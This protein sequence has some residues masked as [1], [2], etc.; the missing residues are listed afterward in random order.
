MY[1]LQVITIQRRI[2]G[3]EI[4]E[5]NLQAHTQRREIRTATCNLLSS[6]DDLAAPLSSLSYAKPEFIGHQNCHD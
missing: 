1:L 5:L 6:D 4:R 2:L 3:V